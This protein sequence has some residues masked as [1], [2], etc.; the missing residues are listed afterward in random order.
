MS[1][2]AKITVA[3]RGLQTN[4][5]E[6]MAQLIGRRP[7]PAGRLHA[8][9]GC[10][11]RVTVY[12]ASVGCFI[13]LVLETKN[14]LPRSVCVHL[15]AIYANL[16]PAGLSPAVH[17]NLHDRET[18]F[19]IWPKQREVYALTWLLEALLIREST[20]SSLRTHGRYPTARRT[21]VDVC[22][23]DHLHQGPCRNS[24]RYLPDAVFGRLS[25]AREIRR[26]EARWERRRVCPARSPL[27][28]PILPYVRGR[29]V[30][31][32]GHKVWNSGAY[33]AITC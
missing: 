14:S 7:C 27:G 4:T 23:I 10:H 33:A 13:D 24:S 15:P 12:K 22:S 1:P 30:H 3:G 28:K 9:R 11:P 32:T 5:L 21:V 20:R 6:L 16:G 18:K 31:V 29:I 8:N 17:I 26:Y 25:M 19:I 2:D